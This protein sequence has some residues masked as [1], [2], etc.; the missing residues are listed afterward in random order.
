VEGATKAT[1]VL[2]QLSI[3]EAAFDPSNGLG[4]VV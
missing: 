3:G 4:A 2:D 1:V